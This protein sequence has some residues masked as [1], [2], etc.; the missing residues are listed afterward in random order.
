MN[1][2]AG[3]ALNDSQN[4]TSSSVNNPNESLIDNLKTPTLFTVDVSMQ[5]PSIPSG[6]I[7]GSTT[8]M[9]TGTTPTPTPTPTKTTPVSST[10][11]PTSLTGSTFADQN[12]N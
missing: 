3:Y 10:S 4:I 12:S 8:P 5:M 2:I 1:G 11:L 7:P 9:P 6:T